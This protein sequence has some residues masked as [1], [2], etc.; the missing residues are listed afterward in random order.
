VTVGIW[1]AV[2][3]DEYVLAAIKDE[4]ARSVFLSKQAAK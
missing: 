1:I 3:H 4:V 2:E